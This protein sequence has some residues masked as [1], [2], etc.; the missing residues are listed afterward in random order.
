MF[1]KSLL[2]RLCVSLCI[3][4]FDGTLCLLPYKATTNRR[5]KI[6]FIRMDNIG[7]FIIWSFN[8]NSI[9]IGFPK[10]NYELIL[11]CNQNFSKLAEQSGLFSKIIPIDVSRFVKSPLYRYSVIRK[12]KKI[13]IVDCAINP[14]Y[15]RDFWRS[16]SIIRAVIAKKKIGLVGDQTNILRCEKKFSD[17][18]Y[19]K[20]VRID[21]SD[22]NEFQRNIKFTRELFPCLSVE[23]SNSYANLFLPYVNKD[24]RKPYVV[25]F[26]G[27]SWVGRQWPVKN[28][29]NLANKLMA[30]GYFCVI[31]GSISDSTIANEINSS[32]FPKLL[33]LTGRTSILELGG[34]IYGADLLITN[35]TS[36]AHIGGAV[37]VP[38][39]CIVGGGHFG[40]F[41]PYS[42]GVDLPAMRMAYAKMSCY[43]C[44]WNCNQGYVGVGSVPCI[45][46]VTVSQ[47]MS[48]IDVLLALHQ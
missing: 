46:G 17:R 36:A 31:A 43:G 7:D 34:L 42:G 41:L 40:R 37:G 39:V 11:I 47:V 35:E 29:I 1:K 15:S 22:E 30:K 20:L 38:T 9:A 23:P 6:L 8:F 26:P 25:L 44:N 5:K 33:D 21:D 2:F 19:T 27:A 48:E 24:I 16:D 28:F 45:S 4:I 32:L 10:V 12:V 18:W 13:G 3:Y 14:T